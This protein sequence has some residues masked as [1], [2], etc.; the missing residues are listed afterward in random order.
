MREKK[1]EMTDRGD[2]GSSQQS[3]DG[4]KTLIQTSMQQVLI[5]FQASTVENETN[6][7]SESS[8]RP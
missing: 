3:Q 8:L 7:Q 2:G 5:C 4:L 6:K 1:K